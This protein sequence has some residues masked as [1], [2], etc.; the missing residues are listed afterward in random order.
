M[1]ERNW[2]FQEDALRK[3]N[4][5]KEKGSEVSNLAVSPKRPEKTHNLIPES[6][7]AETVLQSR[8]RSVNNRGSVLITSIN[9]RAAWPGPAACS[10]GH[11]ANTP[12]YFSV[13]LTPSR[14]AASHGYQERECC[15]LVKYSSICRKVKLRSNSLVD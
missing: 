2:T 13:S 6:E 4:R 15:A 8:S 5:K 11:T 9:I 12:L 3:R 14:P 10:S 1:S 7:V